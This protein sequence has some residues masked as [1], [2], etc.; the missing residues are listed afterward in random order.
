MTIPR[1]KKRKKKKSAEGF[2]AAE[3]HAV[4][5][6]FVDEYVEGIR[7]LGYNPIIVSD[8]ILKF[9]L[10]L[11]GV[12]LYGYQREVA[13]RIIHSIVAFEGETIT[14]LWCRQSGKSETLACVVVTLTVILPLLA[15]IFP[16]LDQFKDGF[17]VGLF[18][19]QSDQ[20]VTTYQRAMARIGSENAHVVLSDDEI[21]VSLEYEAK[22]HLSNGSSLT[23]QTASKT[24]KIES[25]TYDLVI[26]EEA[27]ELESFI[28][29][30]SIEPMVTATGGTIIKCGTTGLV[31]NDFWYEIQRNNKRNRKVTD[32]RLRFHFEYDYEYVIKAKR[33]Q[34]NID[35]KRF[36]LNYEN[37]IKKVI[38]KRGKD[39]E[40]FKLSYAL[41]W[42]L[43]SGM[44]I[45]DKEWLTLINKKKAI[46]MAV[47]PE[48]DICAG[49]DIAK[50]NA[51]TVLT[52][53]KVIEDP[54]GDV[55]KKEIIRWIELHGLNYEIQH[56]VIMAALEQYNVRNLAADYTG[57]G[58]PVV[59]RLIY[60]IG[61][62]VNIIP[63]TF[64]RGSK[65]DMWVALRNDV[66]TRRIVIP[67]NKTARNSEEY[68]RC[69]D[70]LKSMLKYYVGSDL[71]A[72]KAKGNRDD[73]GDSLGLFVIAA[74]D[75]IEAAHEVEETENNPFY[76]NSD[77]HEDISQNSW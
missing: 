65:S 30:K 19:P 77:V 9:G 27:Q 31:K 32:Q 54:N 67:A 60:E 70:Q 71:V 76:N 4:T 73:Y 5:D 62:Y 63:Y 36:H 74:N 56:Q 50:D 16:D 18:A 40:T 47:D 45:T 8:Q 41:V 17:R 66:D 1:T 33:Q 58:R 52:I 2:F 51:S 44:F 6:D 24:S 53:G 57:V 38:S 37:I 49:L 55:P 42:A 28:I 15:A 22:Y 43:E 13:W 48:W 39:S 75:D 23:G 7:D 46:Q 11:T 35:K 10:V 64:S 21:M 26:I 69:E 12:P 3:G 59:D 72:E 20:V 14:M 34:Y 29:E 61:D 68:K 25:K